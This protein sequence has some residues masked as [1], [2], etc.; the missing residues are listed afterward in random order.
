MSHF[1]ASG[2]SP[3]WTKLTGH[4]N[5]DSSLWI[6]WVL[7]IGPCPPPKPTV[8]SQCVRFLFREKPM[9]NLMHS[10][11]SSSPQFDHRLLWLFDKTLPGVRGHFQEPQNHGVTYLRLRLKS[12]RTSGS[13]WRHY[14]AA[15]APR[16]SD[17]SEPTQCD[18][19][20]PFQRG[21]VRNPRK[22]K[23]VST[24]LEE[25]LLLTIDHRLHR[26]GIT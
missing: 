1:W 12:L 9:G 11:S 20:K 2:S 8:D 3:K 16:M 13:G 26:Q 22:K 23:N 7:R 17:K 15:T 25:I 19:M 14:P 18:A 6:L 21:S 5:V 10:P 4:E 24:H